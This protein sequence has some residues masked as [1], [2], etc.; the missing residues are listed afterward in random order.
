MSSEGS[1]T[2]TGRRAGW[3]PRGK[4]RGRGR[5]RRAAPQAVAE[6]PAAAHLR[7]KGTRV[8]E[9]KS[10]PMS[11][12]VRARLTHKGLKVRRSKSIQRNCK[13]EERRRSEK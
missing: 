10:S 8:Y 6:S 2:G 7:Q 9:M 1:R 4:W 11:Q 5:P 3:R 13:G 12:R